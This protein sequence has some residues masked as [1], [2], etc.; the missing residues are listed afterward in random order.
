MGGSYILHSIP[1]RPPLSLSLS[2]SLSL[3]LFVTPA[4]APL[5]APPAPRPPLHRAILVFT[6]SDELG[7]KILAYSP[8]GLGLLTG[9]YDADHL[10][11]GPR[12]KLGKELY[13]RPEYPAALST[14]QAISKA[15]GDV[16]L[17]QVQYS[18][19][20]A[21]TCTTRSTTLH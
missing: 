10:P 16:P 4:R 11:S 2:L 3:P 7:V 14:I 12:S 6:Y 13:A 5:I 19:V 20:H 18:T 8:L 1:K 15:H 17:T 21:R 9:K